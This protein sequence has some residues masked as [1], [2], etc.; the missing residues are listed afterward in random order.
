[1]RAYEEAR[2]TLVSCLQTLEALTE[3]PRRDAVAGARA[4]LQRGAFVIAVVGEFSSGKSFL[5]NALLG[6]MRYER[7]GD[8]AQIV[9]MLAVDINPSTATVTEL[10]YGPR[11]EA[12]AFYEDGRE[13]RIALD[14]LNR[15]VAVGA[16]DVGGLHEATDEAAGAPVRVVVTA[17]SPFLKRGFVVAD[18]PGLASINPA[19]R[20]ATLGFVPNADAVL[21][22]IDTQQPFSEGDAD[23]LAIVRRHV[24]SIFVVQTK[25]DAWQQPQSDGRPAW[26]HARERIATMTAVHAPGAVVNALSAKQYARGVLDGDGEAI[27]R[28]RFPS[29]LAALDASLVARTGRTR[30]RRACEA[31]AAA[32]RDEVAAL[33][34]D[35]ALLELDARALADRR[36]EAAPLLA[37]RAAEA[38]ERSDAVRRREA[39][40]RTALRQRSKAFAREVERTLLHAFDTT[41]IAR[42]RDRERLYVVVD[43]LFAA[44]AEE[45]GRGATEEAAEELEAT[46]AASES[47]EKI[48]SSVVLDAM[49]GPA[50]WLVDRVSSRFAA[51]A[52]YMK[53]ELVA[54]MRG[55]ILPGLDA[56]IAEFVA[57]VEQRFARLYEAL[58]D[59]IEAS[60]E[61]DRDA[62][63]S[64]I[65][66]ALQAHASGAVPARYAELLSRRADVLR[67]ANQAQRLFDA[68]SASHREDFAPV[69]DDLAT[70]AA[71]HAEP[72]FDRSA[73]DRG[74]RP[75]RWRVAVLG[76]LRRGKSSLINAFAGTNLLSDD[77]AGSARF[78]VHVRYGDRRQAFALRPNGDWEE[79]PFDRASA[80]AGETAVLLLVPWTLPPELVLVH[81]PAFDS[82]F[83]HAEDVNAVVATHASEVLCLF[84]R[85]LS[86]REL[87][88][89]A[90]IT[91]LGKPLLFVHTIADNESSSERRHVVELAQRY[92]RERRIPVERTFVISASEY[93]AA[94]S[95]GRA[96]AGWNELDAL[97]ATLEGHAQSH[98]DRLARLARTRSVAGPS[99]SGHGKEGC[100]KPA[101]SGLLGR[102]FGKGR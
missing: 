71:A 85:Q 46:L 83:L 6:K 91:D 36:E 9:G 80:A 45:F 100:E 50:I 39:A 48:V 82:G 44:I 20:R 47:R 18:T 76:A 54:D 86:D 61:A 66:R 56:Q 16:A 13:E 19:H 5:L 12:T 68:W 63:L 93:A 51:A 59:A 89:Y 29:F 26:E 84:S 15:F 28:S 67:V 99:A 17:D 38:R 7:I 10:A 40:F 23:F 27:E 70:I 1:M 98:M 74:L 69:C 65:D 81:A 60:A 24:D 30:L 34:R 73:Y 43:R 33:D 58:A 96:P 14:T 21:Y 87:D 32:S 79:I 2:D 35:A 90:R 22:L 97:R 75:E 3:G 92:L 8:A 64:G 25:I 37:L 53:R 78:P 101:R 55:E 41:D 42:L 11:D 31:A 49:T 4:Q 88:L 62:A 94:R 102:L 77:A 52:G 72:L 95:A 57:A